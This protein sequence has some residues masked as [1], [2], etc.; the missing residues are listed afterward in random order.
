VINLFNTVNYGSYDSWGGG[1]STPAQNKVGGD[2]SH[3]GVPG[4]VAGPMRTVKLS[5]KYAF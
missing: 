5:V 1:P 3:L 4:G 2:N